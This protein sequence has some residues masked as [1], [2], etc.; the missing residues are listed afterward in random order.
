[1]GMA[2]FTDLELRVIALQ[3]NGIRAERIARLLGC[4]R[5]AVYAVVSGVYA[6]TGLRNRAG[7]TRWA[8]QWGLDGMP[9]PTARAKDRTTEARRILELPPRK[10]VQ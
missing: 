10:R 2:G 4:S 3:A 8:M 6:K 1:M 7:L 5:D 9:D